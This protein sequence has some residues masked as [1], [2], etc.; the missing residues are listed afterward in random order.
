MFASAKNEP[1]NIDN[2][3]N[4]LIYERQYNESHLKIKF[5]DDETSLKK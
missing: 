4:K 1:E 2:T 3:R 5:F